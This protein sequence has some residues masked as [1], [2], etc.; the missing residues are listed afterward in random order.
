[1]D[2]SMRQTLST[3]D[4]IHS[5]YMWIQTILSCGKHC[6]TMP[7]GTVSRLRC[8]RRAWGFKISYRWNIV[9]FGKSYVCSNQL[10]VQETNFSFA[11]LNKIRNHFF[12][13]R[14]EDGR[15]SRALLVGSDRYCSSRK[16]ESKH[17]QETCLQL[18]RE[19][20]FLERLM[21]WIMLIV[22]PH[23]LILLIRK[24]CCTSLKTMNPW[25]RW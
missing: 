16:Y 8:C 24:L 20:K 3:F 9:H 10:D 18:Q 14:F 19:R 13:C 6:Q 25:L 11:Q 1:M 17:V 4:L 21:I 2:Q 15:F 22:F 5:S 12:G 23:T 7:I